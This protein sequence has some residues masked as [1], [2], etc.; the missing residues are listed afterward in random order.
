MNVNALC[1]RDNIALNI[2]AFNCF[3][4]LNT[5]WERKPRSEE[6]LCKLGEK[7]ESGSEKSVNW[8]KNSKMEKKVESEIE[9]Q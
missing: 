4:V 6:K 3:L 9:T 5:Q 7:I 1:S 8:E 2:F